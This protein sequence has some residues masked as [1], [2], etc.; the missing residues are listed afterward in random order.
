L[1]TKAPYTT[2]IAR[3]GPCNG[4]LDNQIA[5][6]VRGLGSGLIYYVGTILDDRS[7]SILMDRIAL[8]GAAK[9]VMT[10]PKGIQIP[11]LE[12]CR[13]VSPD[14][15]VVYIM[16]N[17]DPVAKKVPIP[18]PAKEHLSGNAGSGEFRIEPYGVAVMTQLPK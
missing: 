14:K 8:M 13:R 11:G 7:Q 4:W 1:K 17:H 9:T 15:K 18:W 16:I 10:F 3:Y 12:V 2:E 5:I 6:T